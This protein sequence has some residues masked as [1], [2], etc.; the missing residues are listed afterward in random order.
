MNALPVQSGGESRWHAWGWT[1]SVVFH[2]LAVGAAITVVSDLKLAPRPEPFHWEVSLVEKPVPAEHP[3]AASPEPAPPEPRPIDRRPIAQAVQTVQTVRP[4]QQVARVVQQEV[5]RIEP[6][7]QAPAESPRKI[8]QAVGPL[9]SPQREMTEVVSARPAQVVESQTVE[10]VT[11]EAPGVGSVRQTEPV[12][13]QVV[14]SAPS[15]AT[16]APD[17][18]SR[19][20]V[21]AVQP[22]PVIRAPVLETKSEVPTA[23]AP[24]IIE[25]AA[26]SQR[27]VP[28]VP[29]TRAD[30]GWLAEAL[31][32]RVHML[33]RYPPAARLER[34]EGRVVVRAVIKDDGHLLT[35]EVTES[36]GHALLDQH[37]MEVVRLACPLKLKHPLGRPEVVVKVPIN[38]KLEQ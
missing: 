22:S 13:E 19:P 7:A 21:E 4:V 6:V 28:T 12:A 11:R 26:A 16:P 29:L 1:V 9:P 33:K 15:V 23:S 35:V 18:I 10:S 30:Y 3:A 20:A 25:R 8:D 17:V 34:M 36:S 27:P 38:Y 32:Q 24:E 37:A 31:W 5:R 2:G 14:A